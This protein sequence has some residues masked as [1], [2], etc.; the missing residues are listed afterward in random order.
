MIFSL[1]SN[2]ILV[3]RYFIGIPAMRPGQR[4]LYYVSSILPHVGSSLYP[5]V[6]ITCT[7]TSEGSRNDHRTALSRHHNARSGNNYIHDHY[8]A[9]TDNTPNVEQVQQKEKVPKKQKL[10]VYVPPSKY[11][12][13]IIE[14]YLKI[15]S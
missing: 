10:K 2:L 1:K 13:G 11:I 4:H 8:E 14:F 15:D 9:Q 6:C 12:S 7:E 3:H 5:A